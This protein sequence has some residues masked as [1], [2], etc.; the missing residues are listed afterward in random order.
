MGKKR[1]KK[2]KKGK[3]RKKKR[4]ENL[5]INTQISFFFL[6]K[7]QISTLFGQLL[8]KLHQITICVLYRPLPHLHL[9]GNSLL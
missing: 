4:F 1:K 2:E 9:N 6:N 8:V 5:K 3:K 7:P